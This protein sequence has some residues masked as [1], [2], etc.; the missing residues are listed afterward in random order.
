MWGYTFFDLEMHEYL[1]CELIKDMLYIK[2]VRLGCGLV[3]SGYTRY[4]VYSLVWLWVLQ[5]INIAKE[6]RNIRVQQYIG[7]SSTKCSTQWLTNI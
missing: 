5:V 2:C 3:C 6:G 4:T 1:R 7:Y